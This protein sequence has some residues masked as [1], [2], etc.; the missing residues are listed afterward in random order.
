MDK[1][2]YWNA[3]GKEIKPAGMSL[4]QWQELGRDKNSIIANPLFTDPDK[5]DFTLSPDS[6]ALKLGFKPFDYTKAG[7]YGDPAWIKKA[8]EA[9]FPPLEVAP[10]PQPVSSNATK[11]TIFYLDNITLTNEA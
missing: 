10:D 3:A 5:F 6:P 11:Q 7:V 8:A 4:D 2:C 1:N 9:T